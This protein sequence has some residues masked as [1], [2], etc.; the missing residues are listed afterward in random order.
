M[1]SQSKRTFL[2]ASEDAP[3]PQK[4]QAAPTPESAVSQSINPPFD[5]SVDMGTIY[6]S[7]TQDFW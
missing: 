4:K 1:S 6:P 3:I 2:T 7:N 5:P